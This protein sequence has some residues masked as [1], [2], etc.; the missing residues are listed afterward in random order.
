[1]TTMDNPPPRKRSLGDLGSRRRQAVQISDEQLVETG[2]LAPE[3]PL[4]L[5]VRPR[6]EGV[7]LSEWVQGHRELVDRHLA[8]HGGLLFRGFAVGS[9]E[10]FEAFAKA[11]TGQ[12]VDYVEGSSPRILLGERV[13]TS[14]EYPPKYFVSMH[15]ELSYAH[16]WPAKIM[17]FCLHEPES[18][19]E[20]P[21]ADSRRVLERIE[22]EVRRKFAEKGVKY[23]RNLHG[24]QGAG[25]AW[26][27][28]FETDDRA[29]VDDYCRAG[30]IEHRWKDD[31]GL[32]T[33]QVRPGVIRHPVTGEE[34]WFNQADQ[35]HPSNLEP[36]V[37]DALL[38]T[39]PE[40][41]LPI[42]AYFGDGS[43]LDPAELAHVREVFGEVMVAFPWRQGDVLLLDNTLAAH[44]RMPFTGPR[45]VLTA[46]GDSHELPRA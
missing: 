23:V 42:N 41:E 1:M 21:I 38:R 30:G 4:P 37:R 33:S 43:P 28:V 20:T 22:P 29:A 44:G 16:R 36:E 7:D 25:L 35:W 13:Y 5:V 2:L 8:T 6:L 31:G 14:T 15:N 10:K 40:D 11:A 27:T 26:Q 12:L 34:V 46:M 17:F 3:Q 32:W 9:V 39:T 19:G 45:K 24:G 18:G